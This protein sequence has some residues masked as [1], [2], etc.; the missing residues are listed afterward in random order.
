MLGTEFHRN[1]AIT[2]SNYCEES[3]VDLTSNLFICMMYLAP[4]YIFSTVNLVFS[5]K[6]LLSF[7]VLFIT[8]LY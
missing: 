8:I 2:T 3:K 6:K 5:K 4:N 7:L 1:D